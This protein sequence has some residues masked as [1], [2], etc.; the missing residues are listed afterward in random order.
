MIDVYKRLIHVLHNV[1]CPLSYTHTNTHT[2]T[3]TNTH[4]YVYIYMYRTY[5]AIKDAYQRLI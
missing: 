1:L 5:A 3:H 2:Y 4:T